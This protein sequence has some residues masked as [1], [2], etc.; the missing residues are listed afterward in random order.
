MDLRR[1]GLA[2]PALNLRAGRD[3][4]LKI[5]ALVEE[6]RDIAL[7]TTLSGLISPLA[8]GAAAGA[9]AAAGAGAL[10]SSADAGSDAERKVK[11]SERTRVVVAR[12][13]R[14]S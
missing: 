11:E 3:L 12:I 14:A 7:E 9:A 8:A 13:I 4:L 10:A 5:D 6:Q 2:G 1:Q